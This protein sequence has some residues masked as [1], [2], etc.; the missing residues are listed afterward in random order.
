MHIQRGGKNNNGCAFNIHYFLT[1]MKNILTC[2]LNY[3]FQLINERR[4]CKGVNGR[5]VLL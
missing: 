5:S 2:L 4:M 3:E 1:K